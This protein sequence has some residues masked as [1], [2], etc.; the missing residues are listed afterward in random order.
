MA[1]ALDAPAVDL[2][3]PSCPQPEHTRRRRLSLTV[4]IT[5]S[6]PKLTSITD[7][8]GR[9]SSR[10]NAVVARTSSSFGKSLIF[11][12]QQPAGQ[13]GCVPHNLRN[14][15]PPVA[16]RPGARQARPTAAPAQ[17]HPPGR[18][19]FARLTRPRPAPLN[20]HSGPGW[21]PADGQIHHRTTRRPT[22][23]LAA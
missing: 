5:P 16:E 2:A 10:L 17:L 11:D 4:T 18:R 7:A 23:R 21:R 13:G 12:N 6:A 14:F 20:Q 22:N 19:H 1:P 9:R 15:H 3:P 8:P